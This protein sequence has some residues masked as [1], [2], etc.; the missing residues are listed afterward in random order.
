[1]HT[2]NYLTGWYR[3]SRGCGNI[4][5]PISPLLQGC[6]THSPY[7]QLSILSKNLIPNLPYQFL[8]LG[9]PKTSYVYWRT[10]QRHNSSQSSI[11]YLGP[12]RF[13]QYIQGARASRHNTPRPTHLIWHQIHLTNLRDDLAYSIF[14]LNSLNFFPQGYK[15]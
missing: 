2:R 10:P 15:P 1:M 6:G 7:P 3:S 8:A 13:L 14:A 4:L 5:S 9:V 12:L 11:Q